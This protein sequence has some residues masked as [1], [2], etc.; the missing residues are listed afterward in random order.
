MTTSQE[1]RKFDI[2]KFQRN[3]QQMREN[4]RLII[5]NQVDSYGLRIQSCTKTVNE[6]LRP[7][8]FGLGIR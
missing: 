5:N 6:R 2:L 1:H 7:C 4:L 8:M 3:T